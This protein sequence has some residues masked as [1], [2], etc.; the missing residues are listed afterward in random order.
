MNE[1][2]HLKHSHFEDALALLNGTLFI[3]LGIAMFNKAGLL[4]GGTAGFAFLIHYASSLSFGW[5]FFLL[6]LPF[7]Y[8]A[9]KR[10]GWVFTAKT[11]CA[12]SLV[13]VFSSLH[14]Y[15]MQFTT[16]NA[17]YAAVMGGLLIGGGFLILFRHQA[18]LG[19]MNILTLY[20]QDKYGISAGKLQMAIDL[21]IVLLSFFVIDSDKIAASIVGAVAVNV[22]I[23][24]NHRKGRYMSV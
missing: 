9:M 24:L 21:L 14:G 18:S 8:L 6:N 10:M 4:T 16:S 19:G 13:A 3:S 20:L 1:T 12:V 23:A 7:Y 15:F 5:A 2:D 22:V 11:F 17:Y